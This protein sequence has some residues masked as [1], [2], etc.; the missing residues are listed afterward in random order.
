VRFAL[1]SEAGLNDGLAFPFVHAAILLAT[2]GSVSE[3]GLRWLAWD[4]VG[5]V[6]LGALVGTAVGWVLAKLAFRVPYERVRIAASGDALLALAAVLLSYGATELVHGYG[7]LAVF[8]CAMTLRSSQRGHE[9]HQHMH[10]SIQ[11]LERLLTLLVLLLLG[12]S[13]SNALVE[14]SWEGVVVGALLVLVIRPLVGWVSLRVG[15]GMDRAG[16]RGLTPGEK[17]AT[18]WFGVRGVGSIFYLA[19][20]AGEMPID[21]LDQLWATVAFTIALSVL[22]HGVTATPVMRR[23]ESAR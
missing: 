3:W 13:L 20:A 15:A 10:T 18:A 16:D 4:L 8:A 21:D 9:Y 17:V 2:A 11:R 7:F 23:L 6:L 19:Y 1:T 22:V 14:L 12:A 5:K